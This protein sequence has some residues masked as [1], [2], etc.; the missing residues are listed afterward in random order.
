M[1]VL[2]LPEASFMVGDQPVSMEEVYLYPSSGEYLHQHDG[3]MGMDFLRQFN[4]IT[5]N[6][7]DMYLNIE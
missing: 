7:K 3:R 2:L 5:I 6:L 1:E 4:S